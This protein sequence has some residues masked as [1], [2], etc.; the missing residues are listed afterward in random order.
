MRVTAVAVVATSVLITSA[1]E[2]QAF[3]AVP[4]LTQIRDILA[5]FEAPIVSTLV[6]R[7]ALP[8]NPQLYQGHNPPLQA[9]LRARERDAVLHGRYNYGTLE[10][11]FTFSTVAADRATSQNTFPAGRFH[12]DSFV[13]NPNLTAFYIQTLVPSM[14]SSTK[15]YYYHLSNSTQQVVPDPN[16]EDGILSLDVTLLQLLSNRAHVGKIVAEAK[17]A[18]DTVTYTKLIKARNA[19]GIRT[20]LTNT[21]Q[22]ASVLA[23]ADTT[24]IQLSNAWIASGAFVPSTFQD[25]IRT[26]AMKTFRNL[27]DITTEIEVQYLLERLH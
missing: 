17:F 8:V 7:F 25:T 10:Y 19:D 11:P 27:I 23:Q 21:T 26:V 6:Q 1:H 14:N 5:Q 4:A 22:E 24:A 2:S 9:Y 13:G 15:P 3:F 12:Q 20:L 16:R 18:G